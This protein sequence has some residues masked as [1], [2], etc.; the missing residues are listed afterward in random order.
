LVS[1]IVMSLG[2]AAVV[3]ASLGINLLLE[4]MGLPICVVMYIYWMGMASMATCTLTGGYWLT[5]E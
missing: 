1:V 3:R 4:W 2:R 5:V